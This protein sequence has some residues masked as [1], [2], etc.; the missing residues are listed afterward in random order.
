[1]ISQQLIG[2]YPAIFTGGST[3][4][5]PSYHRWKELSLED[6]SLLAWPLAGQIMDVVTET[7]DFRYLKLSEMNS[8]FSCLHCLIFP[9]PE[10]SGKGKPIEFSFFC[11]GGQDMGMLVCIPSTEKKHNIK[12]ANFFVTAW[13]I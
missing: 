6:D 10:F 13:D 8:S 12:W 11:E 4:V 7:E 3:G 5:N 2:R 9:L 1:M